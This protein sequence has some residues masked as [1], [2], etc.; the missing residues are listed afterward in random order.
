[1]DNESWGVRIGSRRFRCVK[2]IPGT[3]LWGLKIRSLLELRKVSNRP[4]FIKME[5]NIQHFDS[6]LLGT[7]VIWM[8]CTSLEPL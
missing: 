2:L 4:V 1:V 5:C 3:R 7:S 6:G 8:V